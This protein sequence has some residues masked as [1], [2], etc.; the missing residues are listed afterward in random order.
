MISKNYYKVVFSSFLFGV[1]LWFADA[2]IDSFILNEG[3]FIQL[4][5]PLDYAHQHELAFRLLF[6]VTFTIVGFIVANLLSRYEITISNPLIKPAIVDMIIGGS[7]LLLVCVFL[8]E[9]EM[10]DEFFSIFQ[11]Y[12]K[13]LRFN[14]LALSILIIL[15]FL[16]VF[17]YRRWDESLKENKRRMDVEGALRSALKASDIE[18]AMTE[19]ILEA[20]GEAVS[21]QDTNFKILYQNAAHVDLIGSSHLGE[22]CYKAY[23]D[24]DNVCENCHLALAFHDGNVHTARQARQTEEG[25]KHYEIIA[26][27]LKDS[28]GK[29]MA[30]IELVREI[31]S[32]VERERALSEQVAVSSL[33]ADI[34]TILNDAGGIQEMLQKCCDSLV[35]HTR[36][37]FARIWTL[38]PGENV[39]ELKASAGMYTH[40]DGGHSRIPAGSYKIGMIASEKRGHYTN[41]VVGD[42]HVNDQ[43]WAK[44]EG[45]KA[46]AGYPLIVDDNV[47]G[48]M[49]VFSRNPVSSNLFAALGEVSGLIALGIKR[50]MAEEKLKQSKLDWESTFEAIK[51]MITIHDN[52]YNIINFN[53]AAQEFLNLHPE[54]TGHPIKCYEYYHGTASPPQRCPSCECLTSGRPSTFE[55][56]EEKFGKHLE[57]RAMPRL[58]TE[59]KVIGVAHIVRDITKRKEMESV[60][61]EAYTELENRVGKRTLELKEANEQLLSEI[62]ERVQLQHELKRSE[63]RYRRFFEDSPVALMEV[64]FSALKKH[65]LKI[66]AS[67]VNDIGDYFNGNPHEVMN[68]ALMLKLNDVNSAALELY[69]ASG[70]KDFTDNFHSIFCEETYDVLKNG[71][72]TVNDGEYEFEGEGITRKFNG[73]KND[74]SLKWTVSSGMEDTFSRVLVSIIDVTQNKAAERALVESE[75]RLRIIIDSTTDLVWEGDTRTGTLTWFGDVDRILKYESGEFPRTISGHMEAIHPA[76]RPKFTDSVDNSLRTG[77]DFNARYRIRCK[78]GTYR[79]WDERGKAIFFEGGKPVKWTGSITDVTDVIRME[80]EARDLQARLI[81]ANKMTALGTLVSGVAHEINNPNSFIMSNSEI[82]SSVWYD[83]TKILDEYHKRNGGL[84]LG[85]LPYS[86]FRGYMPELLKG[87]SEG[88]RRIK[89]IIDNLKD[90][91]RADNTGLDDLIDINEAVSVSASILGHRLRNA[92][93][94]FSIFQK[95]NIPRVRGN[96]QQIEQV[97]I[98]LIVNAMEALAGGECGIRVFTDYDAASRSV[99]IIVEDDGIGI[100]NRDMEHITEPFFTTKSSAGV[101]G[102]GLSIS[103]AIIND[104]KGSMKFESVKGKGTKAIVSLPAA[105]NEEK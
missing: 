65:I 85:G 4:L 67:G 47:V 92:T 26:S 78:D 38:E 104:H 68:C 103:Y 62:N 100:D 39:L 21:M 44:R 18:K 19:G 20:I 48:V 17:S 73:E 90:F 13:L 42:P 59:G 49:A 102:L 98:N 15:L 6:V 55:V 84:Y 50:K 10:S 51:D 63:S 86:E 32:N 105:D 1:F 88:S 35:N 53:K 27:P 91:A 52:D 2:F 77:R 41:N 69:R 101:T 57:I 30:G 81:H 12:S 60:L 99:L 25:E 66:K 75:K 70:K 80:R 22:Y 28:S 11:Y 23:Q 96:R 3:S 83:I 31:S 61:H 34:G 82:L 8:T 24:K 16:V 43:A 29:V 87:I 54:K 93:S 94:N 95:K 76:D 72:I 33:R 89:S 79:I 74:I 58:N 14:E 9:L 36:A 97:M 46:F 7:I 71:F 56:F 64:D 40:L 37:A 5:I 45:M